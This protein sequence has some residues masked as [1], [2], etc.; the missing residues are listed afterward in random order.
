MR[1][2]FN[3]RLGTFT[4][5]T[6]LSD[7]VDA[8]WCVQTSALRSVYMKTVNK[9]SA[10]VAK[11][12]RIGQGGAA[13]GGSDV[14]ILEACSDLYERARQRNPARRSRGTRGWS[15]ITAVALTPEHDVVVNAELRRNDIQSKAAR[16]R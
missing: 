1:G 12:L 13:H 3:F 15:V 14:A 11:M 6:P 2:N 5:S 16:L 9:H 4:S 8:E 10:F 7:G